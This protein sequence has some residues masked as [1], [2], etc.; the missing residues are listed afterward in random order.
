LVHKAQQDV[1]ACQRQVRSAWA[2][3]NKAQASWESA[4]RM[5]DEYAQRYKAE[6]AQAHRLEDSLNQRQFLS[7]IQRLQFAAAQELKRAR[8]VHQQRQQA[9][10]QAE[11]ELR[12]MGKLAQLEA[13]KAAGEARRKDQ[14]EMDAL[15]VARHHFL[16][17]GV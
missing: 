2:D 3:V 17:R 14:R 12:K 4:Q 9:Q 8:G 13:D 5:H 1:E 15:G 7:Q 10:V 16:K 11:L 6:S